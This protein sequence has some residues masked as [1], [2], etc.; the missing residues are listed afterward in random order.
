MTSSKH[1][2]SRIDSNK[3]YLTDKMSSFLIERPNTLFGPCTSACSFDDTPALQGRT[4]PVGHPNQLCSSLACAPAQNHAGTVQPSNIVHG[5]ERAVWDKCTCRP[6]AAACDA[7][8]R[9]N[10]WTWCS[11]SRHSAAALSWCTKSSIPAA[12]DG[13]VGGSLTAT[14]WTRASTGPGI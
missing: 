3:N 10:A 5:H 11:S 7:L 1:A 13:D 4:S 9:C 14:G 8:R 6:F 2:E 12:S